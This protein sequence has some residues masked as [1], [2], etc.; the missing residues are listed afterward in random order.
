MP[1]E[2]TAFAVRQLG[3]IGAYKA[4]GANSDL[5]LAILKVTPADA[6]GKQG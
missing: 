1:W 6:A 4:P 2:L 3:A 5:Y